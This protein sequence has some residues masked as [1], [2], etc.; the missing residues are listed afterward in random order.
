MIDPVVVGG[1]KRIFSDDGAPRP[2]RL[3]SSE[4]A[5]TGAILATYALKADRAAT[6]SQH[7]RREVEGPEAADADEG[8]DDAARAGIVLTLSR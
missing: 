2:L 8:A 6:G 7:V 5:T 3:V 4:V 1:G